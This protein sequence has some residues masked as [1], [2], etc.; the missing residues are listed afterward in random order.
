MYIVS[1]SRTA[2]GGAPQQRAP[3]LPRSPSPTYPNPNYT[4]HKVLIKNDKR[5]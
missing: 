5:I 4:K 1:W 3:P 2:A